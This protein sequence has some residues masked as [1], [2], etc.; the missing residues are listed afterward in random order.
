YV[1]VHEGAVEGPLVPG[2]WSWNADMTA[3]T[4]TPNA[5]LE[6]QTQ[7]VIHI[8]GGMEDQ[9]GHHINFEAHGFGMGGQ[10]MIQRMHQGGQHGYGM[11]QGGG[12]GGGGMGAGWT[13]PSNGSYGMV[14]FFTTA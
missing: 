10:W 4:F 11:G 14:F 9:E 6:A 7:Y 3:L 12:M 13:H 8:G 5:P 1:D 2:A